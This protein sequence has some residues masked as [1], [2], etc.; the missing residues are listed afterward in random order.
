[1][2]DCPQQTDDHTCLLFF[3]VNHLFTVVIV[4]LRAASSS[5]RLQV[6]M[7]HIKFA[8]TGARNGKMSRAPLHF[9]V[10][11]PGELKELSPVCSESFIM[12]AV[13]VYS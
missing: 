8:A 12:T 7:T 10:L 3:F 4:Q 1:M 5:F 11:P 9:T 6:T 2:S 13:T